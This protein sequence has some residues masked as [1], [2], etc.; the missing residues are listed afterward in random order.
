M[1]IMQTVYLMFQDLILQNPLKAE[2]L[3]ASRVLDGLLENN[4]SGK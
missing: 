2:L 1:K 3:L 4:G